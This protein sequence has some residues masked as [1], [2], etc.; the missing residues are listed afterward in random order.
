VWRPGTT[1]A[2]VEASAGRALRHQ[3]EKGAVR[4]SRQ[5]GRAMLWELAG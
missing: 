2:L 3:R 4:N 1:G 5:E